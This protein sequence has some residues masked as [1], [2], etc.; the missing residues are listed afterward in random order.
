MAMVIL[1]LLL[2]VPA[3][4]LMLPLLLLLPPLAMVL[5]LLYM[6][7]LLLYQLLLLLLPGFVEVLFVPLLRQLDQ[8]FPLL[9][10]PQMLFVQVLN[11]E[12]LL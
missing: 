3:A 5:L 4:G 6:L 2:M 11:L 1:Q 9:G 12:R 8:L 7:A 10:Q